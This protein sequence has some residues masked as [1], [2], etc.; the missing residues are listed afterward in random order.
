M[1][2]VRVG[3]VEPH[4]GTRA[5]LRARIA[6]VERLA[7][8]A[9]AEG[10]FEG[11]SML[12]DFAAAG[13]PIAVLLLDLPADPEDARAIVEL[14]AERY[15]ELRVVTTARR[16]DPEAIR[17]ALL[18]GASGCVSKDA[19]TDEL[20]WAVRGAARGDVVMGRRI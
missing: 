10:P 5:W 20:G 18:A 8:I 12:D 9:E 11:L 3:I 2:R 1:G 15:P 17:A 16:P 13:V 19:S 6:A 14:I 7:P 4:A